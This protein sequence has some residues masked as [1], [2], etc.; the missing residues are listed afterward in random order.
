MMHG[1]VEARPGR[2]C[3]A[4]RTSAVHDK[5]QDAASALLSSSQRAHCTYMHSRAVHCASRAQWYVGVVDAGGS[6][7]VRAV[8]SA[9]TAKAEERA[10]VPA[11][12]QAALRV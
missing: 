9:H 1:T 12:M 4:R 11:V 6:V 8:H 2:G 5:G 7:L 10:A 3:R